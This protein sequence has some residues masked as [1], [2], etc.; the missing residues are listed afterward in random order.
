MIKYSFQ[1][2]SLLHRLL[3]RILVLEKEFPVLVARVS[4]IEILLKIF[5]C[6]AF[7][8]QEFCLLFNLVSRTSILLERITIKIII[9]I[10]ILVLKRRKCYLGNLVSYLLI[11]LVK[12]SN[13]HTKCALKYISFRSRKL[14]EI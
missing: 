10:R 4:E 3:K 5:R 8:P 6:N 7:L 12:N 13:S 14:I 9:L 2:N 11:I 1:K